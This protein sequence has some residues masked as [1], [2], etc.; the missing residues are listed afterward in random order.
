[1]YIYKPRTRNHDKS[2]TLC[3]MLYFVYKT[4]TRKQTLH[5]STLLG[6]DSFRFLFIRVTQIFNST[7]YQACYI[8]LLRKTLDQKQF[9]QVKTKKQKTKKFK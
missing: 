3:G 2:Y 5:A 7:Q 1:M 6:V 8:T 9:N 4:A